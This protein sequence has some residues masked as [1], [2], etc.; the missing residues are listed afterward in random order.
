MAAPA[1]MD[2]WPVAYPAASMHFVLASQALTDT[3]G[4]VF[5]YFVLLPA[6][7]TGLIVV[8]IVTAKGEKRE[9]EKRAGRWGRKRGPADHA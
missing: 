8:T 1:G 7:A 4:L 9:D 2:G 6:I 5:T 3:I